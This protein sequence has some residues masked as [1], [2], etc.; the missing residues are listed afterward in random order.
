[1]ITVASFA[2]NL[3]FLFKYAHIWLANGCVH[4]I[5]SGDFSC[6]SDVCVVYLICMVESIN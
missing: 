1:M 2:S 6:N 5:K 4:I 3:P